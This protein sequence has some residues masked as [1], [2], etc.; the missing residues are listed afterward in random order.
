M[1]AM[2]GTLTGTFHVSRRDT[3]RFL[4]ENLGVKV[5][6]GTISNTEAIV[7]AAL[8]AAHAEA[9][10][11]VWRAPVRNVDETGHAGPDGKTAWVV[12]TPQAIH[13]G[14]DRSRASLVKVVDVDVGVIGSD[15]YAVYNI[16]SPD[17][18]QLCWAACGSRLPGPR[19]R[20]RRARSRRSNAADDGARGAAWLE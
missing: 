1:Q 16:V 7:S 19:R 9:H 5:S 3:E 4:D 20:R 13:V 11:H 15:R 8:A 2:I 6:L 17:R 12:S 14:L 18:R 10:E